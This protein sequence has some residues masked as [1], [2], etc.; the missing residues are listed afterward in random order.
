MK[1]ECDLGTPVYQ[2]DFEIC[3]LWPPGGL[4]WDSRLVLAGLGWAGWSG[5]AGLTG[6]AELDLSFINLALKFVNY[7]LLR[8]LNGFPLPDSLGNPLMGLLKTIVASPC[9]LDMV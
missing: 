4:E 7:G 1:Q 2:S 6:L 5:W 8:S 3:K 9:L